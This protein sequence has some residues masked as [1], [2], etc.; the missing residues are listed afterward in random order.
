MHQEALILV[1]LNK[2]R[3]SPTSAFDYMNRTGL[4]SA[5]ITDS[6]AYEAEMITELVEGPEAI[7]T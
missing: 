6:T 3:A 2:Q 7:G 5:T 4:G 1:L